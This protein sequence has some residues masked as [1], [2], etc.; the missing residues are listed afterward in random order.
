MPI[1]EECRAPGFRPELEL[2][3]P[4]TELFATLQ[5]SVLLTRLRELAPEAILAETGERRI[6]VSPAL[7]ALRFR[8]ETTRELI[9]EPPPPEPVTVVEDVL[10]ESPPAS[11]RGVAPDGEA[12]PANPDPP[13]A[14]TTQG[15]ES[16][17][18]GGQSILPPPPP[19]PPQTPLARPVAIPVEKMSLKKFLPILRRK[20]VPAPPQEPSAAAATEG[21]G[22]QVPGEAGAVEQAPQPVEMTSPP[23]SEAPRPRIELPK[24]RMATVSP[25]ASSEEEVD[26]PP[27]FEPEPEPPPSSH[28]D[29]PPIE[30]SAEEAPEPETIP[31]TPPEP[32]IL[33][34]VRHKEAPPAAPEAGVARLQGIF[35]TEENLSAERVL[36]LCGGLPGVHSC[37]LA[38]GA[39]ILATHNVPPGLDLISL[40]AN[41]ADMLAAMRA[42]SMRMGLGAIPAVTVH[43][44]KGP[45]SFFHADDLAMLVFHADRGFVPGVRER[46]HDVVVA[47]KSSLLL[48]PS[49]QE[50]ARP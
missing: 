6:S 50:D 48:L 19:P 13:P 47:L 33:L 32:E 43:S 25:P 18:P 5:P 3:V 42:S 40:T 24:R 49:G 23:R 35:M 4:C 1:P 36:E 26:A 28:P 20:A 45:V 38:R 37:V 29:T 16:G 11:M 27:E 30:M 9:E 31:P 14:L 7:L 41:A 44:E 12:P 39:S 10:E 34:P 15:Q 2:S 46:L 17:I 22:E 21:M 8:F